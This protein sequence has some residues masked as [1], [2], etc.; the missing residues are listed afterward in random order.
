VTTLLKRPDRIDRLP[1][2][3]TG[4]A[5]DLPTGTR[6]GLRS[7][8]RGAA[9]GAGGGLVWGIAARIW[10]R[11]VATDPSFTWS[12]TLLILGAATLAG[13]LFGV[14][15]A[16]RNSRFPRVARTVGA[17]SILPLGV[18]A[19]VVILPTVVAATLAAGRV[20]RLPGRLL[21]AALPCIGILAIGLDGPTRRWVAVGLVALVGLGVAVRTFRPLMVLY[22]LTAAGLV[23]VPMFDGS[24]SVTRAA[25]TSVLYVALLLPLTLAFHGAV[26]RRDIRSDLSDPPTAVGGN[27]PPE[28]HE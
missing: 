14:A 2:S 21:A 7:A 9:L 16:G 17:V 12:G 23:I 20:P 1:A 18:G 11:L 10:M 6:Q 8:L 26:R 24:R 28:E 13:T 27:E 4:R 5:P 22:A 15:I 19:G 3:H 25:V